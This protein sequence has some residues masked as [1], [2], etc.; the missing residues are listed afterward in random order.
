MNIKDEVDIFNG[1]V[2][3]MILNKRYIN[4]YI[5]VEKPPRN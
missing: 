5:T 1:K 4:I 2:K 3:K